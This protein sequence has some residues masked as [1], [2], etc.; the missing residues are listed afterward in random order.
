M[1]KQTIVILTTLFAVSSAFA[2]P[3]FKAEGNKEVSNKIE[4]VL[5]Q[6]A[7]DQKQETFVKIHEQVIASNS[8][9]K[10]DIVTPAFANETFKATVDIKATDKQT[11]GDIVLSLYAPKGTKASVKIEQHYT[12]A[13]SND[14]HAPVELI[15]HVT[16][17]GKETTFVAAQV[18]AIELAYIVDYD[19]PSQNLPLEGAT[20]KCPR[21]GAEDRYHCNASHT[22]PCVNEAVKPQKPAQEVVWERKHDKDCHDEY[23]CNCPSVVAE[24]VGNTLKGEKIDAT[25][26]VDAAYFKAVIFNTEDG[27]SYKVT[28]KNG[29][30][31]K[32]KVVTDPKT[33][34]DPHQSLDTNL[35]IDEVDGNGKLKQ[36]TAIFI[37]SRDATTF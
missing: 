24:I 31:L 2:L 37:I 28:P 30:E 11:Y 16:I 36:T 34:G 9:S 13:V 14:P 21:C 23:H 32:V 4:T 10:D 22:G 12:Y 29:A 25:K 1:K 3:A 5:Q 8:F 17:N 26:T 35:V 7:Q 20:G 6:K 19:A 33:N 15:A 18:E 27:I